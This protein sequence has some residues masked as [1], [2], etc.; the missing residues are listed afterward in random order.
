MKKFLPLG[1]LL[2]GA[3]WLGGIFYSLPDTEKMLNQAAQDKLAEGSYRGDFK[4]VVARFS[5]QEAT[6][7]GV[8]ALEKDKQLAE[9]V[10]RTELRLPEHRGAS[11][12]PVI[13]VY[14][15]IRV[16]PQSSD[17]KAPWLIASIFPGNQR[18]DG[19]L[20]APAYRSKLLSE[21]GAKLVAGSLENQIL[22]D[23]AS[24]P[25]VD[26]NAT[27]ENVPD[28]KKILKGKTGLEQRLIAV[29]SCDGN[30]TQFP[31]TASDAEVAAVLK[32]TKIMPA[33]ITHALAA[34]RAWP[35]PS[36][37]VEQTAPP[38]TAAPE[39]PNVLGNSAYIGLYALNKKL[40]LYGYVPTEDQKNAAITVAKS[41]YPSFEVDGTQIQVARQ[42][43]VEVPARLVL[44]T[45][46]ADKTTFT[47]FALFDGTSKLY[48]PDVF[49]SEI[50]K[51]FAAVKFEDSE[52][53]N[54]LAAYRSEL[55]TSGAVSRDEPYISLFTDGKVI[56]VRGEVADPETKAKLLEK[57]TA[58]NPSIPI[59]EKIR[60][61]VLVNPVPDVSSTVESTPTFGGTQAGVAIARPGQ[62]WRTAVVHAIYFKTGSNRSTDQDRALRQMRRVLDLIPT[63]TFEIVGHTD[64]VGNAAAN[65]KLS[66]SRADSFQALSTS[67]GFAPSILTTRGAGPDEPIAPNDNESGRS[68]N[69][70]VDVMLK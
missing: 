18:V 11:Y 59:T 34:I 60:V 54:A 26:W 16:D 20:S 7:T 27:L 49:D 36:A 9:K 45:A 15:E 65:K 30:W 33:E 56:Q 32:N 21:A 6:L 70:R 44:P 52:I 14:N 22:V 25:A 46:P 63:A 37:V 12:N 19:L 48:G 50:E 69:R 39:P 51:D 8:V 67:S 2:S 1:L 28:F 61:S 4:K 42:R 23:D 24:L 31:A 17:R 5:G 57:I 43:N 35:P 41:T 47:G 66:L 68:L 3:L 55:A 13:H 53:T 62:K 29:T 38:V 10:I 64:N 58:A 40:S